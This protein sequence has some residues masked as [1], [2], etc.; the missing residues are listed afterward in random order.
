MPTTATATLAVQLELS[1]TGQAETG[2]V[3]HAILHAKHAS[4]THPTAPAVSMASATCK[5]QLYNS[6]ASLDAL[7]A[8]TSTETESV[9]SATSVVP[10]V[11]VQPPTASPAPKDK[12]SI[13]EDV[14]PVAPPSPTP[15]MDSTPPALTAALTDTGNVHPP[16]AFPALLSAPL[17]ADQP[18]TVLP[19]FRDQ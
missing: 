6:L 15:K 12:S 1:E 3:S 11:S 16:P 5:P 4:I 18:P 7:T 10:P 2:T 9:R 13:R 14:G 8:P 19:A 17:A